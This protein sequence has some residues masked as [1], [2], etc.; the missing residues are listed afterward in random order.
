[1][2]GGV[3]AGLAGLA[4]CGGDELVLL[5]HTAYS[6]GVQVYAPELG[7]RGDCAEELRTR[8]CVEELV[9]IGVLDVGPASER[10]IT[11][12]DDDGEGGCS[13]VLWL[14]LLFL[15]E[16]GPVD[17]PGTLLAL[18]VEAALEVGAGAIHTVAF[19]QAT[20]R[21]DEVGGDDLNQGGPPLTCAEL[22]RSPGRP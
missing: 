19:P 7:L 8:F 17:D 16:V 10:T 22:D 9:P 13:R 4:G 21:I 11:V 15:G 5:N 14:R 3:L 12:L 20:V 18:P 2:L 1:M 6:A